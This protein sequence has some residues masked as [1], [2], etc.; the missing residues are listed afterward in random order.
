MVLFVCVALV[1]VASISKPF[2][3]G[4]VTVRI[5]LVELVYDVVIA[6]NDGSTSCCVVAFLILD[7]GMFFLF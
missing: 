7:I 2:D 6:V 3:R 4:R 1:C 5:K